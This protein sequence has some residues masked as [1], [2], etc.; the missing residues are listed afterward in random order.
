[1]NNVDSLDDARCQ[2]QSHQ[3]K[4][5]IKIRDVYAVEGYIR[6]IFTEP[7][8]T[9]VCQDILDL[10]LFLYAKPLMLK[11]EYSDQCETVLYYP[12]HDTWHSI[13]HRIKA[14]FICLSQV[15]SLTQHKAVKGGKYDENNWQSCQWNAKHPFKAQ[16][17]TK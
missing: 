3:A 7:Y 1:M 16:L 2:T 17:V 10:V 13:A 12:S 14:Q 4:K 9:N 6:L 11:V 5:D 15:I 8:N